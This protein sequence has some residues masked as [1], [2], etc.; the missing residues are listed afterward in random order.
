M[1]QHKRI[2]ISDATQMQ[3]KLFQGSNV[4]STASERTSDSVHMT[5]HLVHLGG[6]VE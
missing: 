6:L 3:Y 1:V 4:H 5:V 2:L